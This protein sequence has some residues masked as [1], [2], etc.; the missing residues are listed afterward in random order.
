METLIFKTADTAILDQ[1]GALL[2]AGE[3]VCFP[4]E[5]VY[6]LGANALN[7]DAVAKIFQTK[8]RP[9][10]VVSKRS[11]SF[12]RLISGKEGRFLFS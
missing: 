5:T 10:G 7:A 3:L 2:R 12:F 8:N 11:I 9:I 1:C 4:T 6:G